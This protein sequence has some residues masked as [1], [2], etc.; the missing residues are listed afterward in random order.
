MKPQPPV[1]L[2]G[3]GQTWV[4][5]ESPIWRASDGLGCGRCGDPAVAQAPGRKPGR[6]RYRCDGCLQPFEWRQG[7]RVWQWRAE[8]YFDNDEAKRQRVMA[9][10][11][12]VR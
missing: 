6:N 11:G 8:P 5:V 3:P 1:S 4:V 7:D 10:S 9:P 2:L 12:R